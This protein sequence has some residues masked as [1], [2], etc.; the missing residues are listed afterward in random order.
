MRS[1]KKTQT[2]Y[3]SSFAEIFQQDSAPPPADNGT[4]PILKKEK[5]ALTRPGAGRL[6]PISVNEGLKK[7]SRGLLP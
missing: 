3:I 5:A 1:K 7:G 2:F 4:A 6:N